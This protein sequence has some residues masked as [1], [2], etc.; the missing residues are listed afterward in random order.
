MRRAI[1]VVGLLAT[2]AAVLPA[3][4]TLST[5]GL[6]YPGGQLSTRAR[7]MGGAAGE[8]D[9][10]SPLNPAAL[11]MLLTPILGFQ[12]EPEHREVTIGTQ[13]VTSSVS[14]FPLFVGA[15]PLGTRWRV[16]LSASTL[17]DRTFQ[18]TVQDTQDVGGDEV[19]SSVTER[20]EG[21]IT[22]VRLGVAYALTRWLSVGLGGHA[23][24]GSDALSTSRVFEDTVRFAT[25]SQR[26]SIGF[27][28]NAI[29]AGALAMV[30]RVGAIG[31]SYRLGGSMNAYEGDEVVGSGRAPDHFG[32][33]LLYLGIRGTTIGVRAARDEW[34]KLKGMTGA[35][36]IHE[37]WD[38]GV[39]ADVTGPRFAGSAIDLRAGARWRTL[40]FSASGNPVT[41]QTW[42]A[43]FMLP[44]GRLFGSTRAVELNFGALRAT[45]SSA[46]I[47]GPSGPV[48]VSE[49]SWIISTGF[50]V[51]P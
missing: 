35:L 41:E 23:L 3:Q 39:G 2:A 14:R 6:G 4:G 48:A 42:S 24:T 22:D 9:P 16:A 51:R 5:Q 28:G 44:M 18:T 11:G 46:G 45:R 32:V 26:T 50:S 38:I 13:R 36:N 29:S 47:P 19:I 27:G 37:D 15:L 30:S 7:T 8:A 34:S 17:L 43:G 25:S 33:S 1:A 21:S 12:A 31:V 20:S 40:P 10:L 49:K